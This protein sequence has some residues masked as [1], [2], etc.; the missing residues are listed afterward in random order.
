MLNALE[1]DRTVPI[2]S[3]KSEILPSMWCTGDNLTK[4]CPGR[5]HNIILNLTSSLLFKL[6][7]K[8]RITEANLATHTFDKRNVS[9]VEVGRSPCQRPG[10]EGDDQHREPV[11]FGA[12]QQRQGDLVVLRPVQLVPPFPVA[13]CCSHVFYG[14]GTC[15]AHCVR[16]SLLCADLCQTRFFLVTEDTLDSDRSHDEWVIVFLAKE[17]N[18]AVLSFHLEVQQVSLFCGVAIGEELWANTA[19]HPGNPVSK[20]RHRSTRA[21]TAIGNLQFPL[22]KSQSIAIHRCFLTRPPSDIIE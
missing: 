14:T 16:C 21:I 6:S 5:T 10:V 11:C 20:V 7:S 2:L 15:C 4:P 13:V 9:I 1:K 19:H 8:D 22:P 18:G 3:H 17:L 12:L